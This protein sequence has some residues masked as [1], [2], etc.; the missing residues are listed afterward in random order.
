MLGEIILDSGAFTEY[1]KGK[2]IDIEKYAEF[3]NE[4]KHMFKFCFNLDVIGD[5]K[6]SYANWMWLNRNGVE[7]LPIYHMGTPIKYLEKYLEVAEY[8]GIGA[9]ANLSTVKRVAGLD[10]LFRKYFM[11]SNGVA[12]KKVHGLGLTSFDVLEKFPWWSTDSISPVVAAIWGTLYLPTI[13]AG[14]PNYRNIFLSSVSSRRK[15]VQGTQSYYTLPKLLH[16]KYEE[17]FNERG[18]QVSPL[19]G[20]K[21]E[22]REG[23]LNEHWESRIYWNLYVWKK[24]LEELPKYQNV[25]GPDRRSDVYVCV[26]SDRAV[27]QVIRSKEAHNLLIS[28]AYFYKE[29][30]MNFLK[31]IKNKSV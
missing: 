10:A 8:I 1:K 27:E 5:A 29:K 23:F 31:S 3:V 17:L 9:I 21:D 28:F 24:Y 13:R 14:V 19:G 26:S 4:N 18:F 20:E 22:E 12:I 11:D 25:F 7:T 6:K 2:V 15:H 30:H 16:S